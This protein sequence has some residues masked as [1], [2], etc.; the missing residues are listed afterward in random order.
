MTVFTNTQHLFFMSLSPFYILNHVE[1]RSP[2]LHVTN[3]APALTLTFSMFL[4]Y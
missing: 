3:V 4:L 2:I 1:R